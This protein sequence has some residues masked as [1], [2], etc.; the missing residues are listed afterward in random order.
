LQFFSQEESYMIELDA[1]DLQVKIP[2]DY[3]G[4]RL[5]QALARCLPLHSRTRLAQWMKEKQV[6]VN[7]KCDAAPK[8]KVKGGE[9]VHIYALLLPQ[10]ADLPQAIP[11]NIV[12]EDEALLVIDK[13][14]GLVVHPGAG[15]QQ[16]TLLNALLY[17]HPRLQQIPRAGIVH[18]LDK[19]TTGLMMVAKTLSSHTALVSALQK[20]EVRREYVALVGKEVIAGGTFDGAIG[21]DPHHRLKMAVIPS[22]KPACTHVRCKTRYAGFTLMQA[23][24]ET[25]RTHQIRVHLSHAGLPLVGKPVTPYR[26]L[27][28]RPRLRRELRSPSSPQNGVRV[29]FQESPLNIKKK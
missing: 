6:S 23:V 8:S 27:A 9:V 24:L 18:R 28:S 4:M 17:Y 13:P 3:Q 11:L 15:N 22:G 25:G 5:D 16:G 29:E 10:Q 19:E 12:Y 1:I 21:R 7:G 26:A 2:I 14:A 20:R